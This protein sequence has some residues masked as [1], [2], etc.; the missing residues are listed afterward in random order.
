MEVI[1]FLIVKEHFI[2]LISSSSILN[3]FSIVE[4]AVFVDVHIHGYLWGDLS[5][6]FYLCRMNGW[7]FSFH[8]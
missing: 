7:E 8:K 6:V 1:V 2:I 4:P 3:F 5:R